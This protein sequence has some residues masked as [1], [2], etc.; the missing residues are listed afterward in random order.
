MTGRGHRGAQPPGLPSPAAV[1]RCNGI[2]CELWSR[3]RQRS[4][5]PAPPETQAAPKTRGEFATRPPAPLAGTNPPRAPLPPTAVPPVSPWGHLR[6]SFTH[7]PSTFLSTP[8]VTAASTPPR[9]APRSATPATPSPPN[10][11]PRAPRTAAPRRPSCPVSPLG[12]HAIGA[13][14]GFSFLRSLPFHSLR[15][16]HDVAPLAHQQSRGKVYLPPRLPVHPPPDGVN[17]KPAGV[18]PPPPSFIKIPPG[19]RGRGGGGGGGPPP[20]SPR[21]PERPA[22][23]PPMPAHTTKHEA[24]PPPAGSDDRSAPPNH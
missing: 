7:S 11:F 22:D 19:A 15:S 4:P 16:L 13:T 24:L 20:P 9:S 8:R 6:A 14:A 17:T 10:P 5:R 23:P 3:Q 2:Q 12:S 21:P 18:S 1:P